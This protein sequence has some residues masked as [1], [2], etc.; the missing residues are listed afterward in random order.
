HRDIHGHVD[1][2]VLEWAYL[3]SYYQ[4]GLKSLLDRAV[5][6]HVELNHEMDV[7]QDVEKIDEIPFDFVR[8]R[9]SVVVSHPD[10]A[11]VLIC[12]GAVDEM[13]GVC[14]SVDVASGVEPFSETRRAEA[15][16]VVRELNEEGFRVVAVAHKTVRADQQVFAVAD[17]A[18]LVLA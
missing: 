3:N 1:L 9:M 8:R 14:T 10:R 17:E 5:L 6:E 15:T 13:F 7:L 16:R 2:R 4:T 12:K 18:E 11:R